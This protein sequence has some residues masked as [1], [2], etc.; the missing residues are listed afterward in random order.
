MKDN[1]TKMVHTANTLD[2]LV[3]VGGGIFRAAGIV[4]AIF[5]VLV[6]L[7]GGKMV[8]FGSLSLDLDFIKLY[9][10]DEYQ[11]IT[12]SMRLYICIGLVSSSLLCFVMD[13]SA[14]VARQILRPMKDG[15]PFSEEVSPNLRKMALVV[16]IGGAAAQLLGI[17]ERALAVYAFPMDQIF[18]SAAIAKSEYVFIM[19][20]NFVLIACV[21]LFLSYIFTYGQKLQQESDETL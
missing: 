9:L 18:D 8:E 14:S 7:L 6:L 21:I 13:Y 4:L 15:R 12:T 17:A 20:F 19:D 10:T 11:T 5:A 1:H 3:R 16:L 2:T